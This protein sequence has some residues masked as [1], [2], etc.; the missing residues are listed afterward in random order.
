M[1]SKRRDFLKSSGMVIMGGAAG[2]FTAEQFVR[3][4]G[5]FS[6]GSSKVGG[7]VGG[8]SGE[9][10]SPVDDA[11]SL[12][13]QRPTLVTIF[14]RGGADSLNAFVPY[15]DDNYYKY[16]PT[17]AIGAKGDKGGAGVTKIKGNDYWGLN[18][19]LAGMLPLFEQGV[20]VP[21]INVG[22]PH[23]TRS[24]FSA[25]DYMER[26]AESISRSVEEAV[27]CA[28][29][30]PLGPG[31]SAAGFARGLS[32]AGGRQSHGAHGTVRGPVRAAEHGKHDRP[33]RRGSDQRLASRRAA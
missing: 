27:R 25:Q 3:G 18:P 23:D 7:N 21:I 8:A 20:M 11:V 2:F 9:K 16:R 31:A 28:A 15:G 22:S 4:E 29:S 13:K 6:L 19:G 14:L 26:L 10:T 17:I 32:R 30:R 12:A 1:D 24:H 5:P 33:R